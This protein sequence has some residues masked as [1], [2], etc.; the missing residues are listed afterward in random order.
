VG[1]NW[2][3]VAGDAPF[4]AV[5]LEGA[6]KEV[7]LVVE[8]GVRGAGWEEDLVMEDA[9]ELTLAAVGWDADESGEE[10]GVVRDHEDGFLFVDVV[11]VKG[12]G[13]CRSCAD[14]GPNGVGLGSGGCMQLALVACAQQLGKGEGKGVRSREEE[15]F[16]EEVECVTVVVVEVFVDEWEEFGNHG[17]GDCDR[18][19]GSGR[20]RSAGGGEDVVDA[21]QQSGVA[22]E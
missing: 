15:V 9:D 19:T 8:K 4:V 12:V 16:V 22:F 13:G 17:A 3:L 6:L 18:K 5:G 14:G 21:G 1:A 10:G 20:E 11:E 7:V 2:Q